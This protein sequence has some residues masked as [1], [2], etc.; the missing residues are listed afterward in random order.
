MLVTMGDRLSS[1]DRLVA[2]MMREGREDVNEGKGYGTGCE[3]VVERGGTAECGEVDGVLV[4]GRRTAFRRVSELPLSVGDEG[5]AMVCNTEGV[6]TGA[7]GE[8]EEEPG[9]V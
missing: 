2:S 6:K 9:P 8:R 1:A 4:L 5:V 3:S 7:I